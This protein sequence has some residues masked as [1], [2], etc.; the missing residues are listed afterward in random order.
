MKVKAARAD[1][2]QAVGIRMTAHAELSGGA[3]LGRAS[4]GHV[5]VE[6]SPL[7]GVVFG[8]SQCDR[9]TVRARILEHERSERLRLFG[10]YLLG[11][12]GVQ[13]CY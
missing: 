9:S 10:Q 6:R 11:A 12:G 3:Q 2:A 7:R 5:E 8:G 4:V 13:L 1:F